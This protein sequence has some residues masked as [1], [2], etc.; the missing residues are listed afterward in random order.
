MHILINALNRFSKPTGICR[1]ATNIALSILDR[2]EIYKITLVI[3]TWQI[4]SFNSILPNSANGKIEFIFIK[5]RNNSLSRNFWFLFG[6]PKIVSDI[7]PDIVYLSFPIPFIKQFFATTVIATVHDLYPYE[8]PENFGVVQSLFNRFFLKVCVEW[9]DALVCVSQATKTSLLNYFPKIELYKRVEVIYNYIDFSDTCSVMP[10]CSIDIGNSPFLLCVA[11]H[12]KNKNIDKLLH[13]Y[14]VLLK[15]N[16]L[17]QEYFLV[18]VGSL[19]P[20]TNRI[21]TLVQELELTDR[22]FLLSGVSDS[23]LRWLYEN[24]NLFVIPSSKEGFCLP[25][26]EALYFSC[27]VVCS[28]IPV[29]REIGDANCTY[30]QLEGDKTIDNLVESI[31]YS[32]DEKVSGCIFTDSRFTRDTSAKSFAKLFLEQ[33]KD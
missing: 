5:I 9:A 31:I 7:A 30:F 18:L 8:L 17:S 1:H 6:L 3:G 27:K 16:I 19:G 10:Y 4:D 21:L 13:A 25:L 29:L 14:S 33:L 22:V 11:Q 23:E 24:C 12:R 32:M 28:D 15:D 2:P 26:I 20:E